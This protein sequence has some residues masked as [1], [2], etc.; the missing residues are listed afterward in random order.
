[1]QQVPISWQHVTY[2]TKVSTVLSIDRS[3]AMIQK[4]LANLST[5]LACANIPEYST[6]RL[7]CSSV[8]VIKMEFCCSYRPKIWLQGKLKLK[9]IKKMFTCS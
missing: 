7:L 2:L 1:M 3:R 8:P 4:V 6:I 9:K 5:L